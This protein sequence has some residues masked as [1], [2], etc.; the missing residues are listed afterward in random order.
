MKALSLR[1]PYAE[2]IVN[3]KKTI[4]IRSWRTNFCGEFLVHASKTIMLDDCKQH[5]LDPK[6]LITGAIL[7]KAIVTG[8]K[9]YETQEEFNADAD[10][11][12]ASPK[13]FKKP[14][15]GFIL[16]N[17]TQLDQ[18]IPARGWLNFFNVEL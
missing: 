8:V 5:G 17:P 1:Q 15:Y 14:C 9:K 4:E 7:G 16:E 13:F 11:H 3:G 18:P 6:T 2:L 12:L 10:K